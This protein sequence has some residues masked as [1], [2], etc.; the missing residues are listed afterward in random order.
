MAVEK[1]FGLLYADET[2]SKRIAK[3]KSVKNRMGT[4]DYLKKIY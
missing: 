2:K 4:L 1:A 3:R